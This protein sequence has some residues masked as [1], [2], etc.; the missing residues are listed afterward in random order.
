MAHLHLPHDFFERA[1]FPWQQKLQHGA[2]VIGTQQWHLIAMDDPLLQNE[3]ESHHAHRNVMMPSQPAAHL[4]LIHADRAFPVLEG[5]FDP[6]SLSLHADEAPRCDIVMRIAERIFDFVAAVLANEQRP[7]PRIGLLSIPQPDGSAVDGG[8]ERSRRRFAYCDSPPVTPFEGSAYIVN[9]D[10]FGTGLKL[11]RLTPPHAGLRG[12]LRLWIREVH[13]LV[14]VDIGHEHLASVVK[15]PEEFPTV[16]VQSVSADTGETHADLSL[17]GDDVHGEFDFTL[18]HD[19]LL[20]DPD[21]RA[22]IRIVHPF[23]RQEKT[24]V[25]K[26]R[27][28]ARAKR[29]EHG[30][31]T[32]VEFPEPAIILPGDSD[33]IL[34]FLREPGLIY[35]QACVGRAAKN[36]IHL[37][38]DAIHKRLSF[39]RRTA[40]E[41]LRGIVVRSFDHLL[42]AFHVA[43][44]RLNE[45][46]KIVICLFRVVLP[47]AN[48]KIGKRTGIF[49]EI[50]AQRLKPYSNVI[51]N[52]FI[53]C[54]LL[55]LAGLRRIQFFPAE[56]LL[57]SPLSFLVYQQ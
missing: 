8:F 26:S 5:A 23:V 44:W 15:P 50:P 19:H 57:M 51:A 21:L 20:G 33:G 36:A 46:T 35:K 2:D 18:C 22:A 3:K 43:L 16:A 29:P 39:P 1:I 52:I 14:D 27:M 9:P 17:M 37:A 45:S 42:H 31:L 28:L 24:R 6:E 53:P 32:V 54:I 55:L 7:L 49:H 47:V 4:V 40:N 56:F 48:E 38:G 13:E 34:P 12:N 25:H 30:H 41:M 11:G 10:G